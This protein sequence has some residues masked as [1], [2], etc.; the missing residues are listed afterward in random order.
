MRTGDV[1]GSPS[2]MPP[3]QAA[4]R[5]D[6]VGPHSDVYSLGAILY[7]LLTGPTAVPGRYDLGNDLPGA[8]DTS[9]P[10]ATTESGRTPRPGNHLP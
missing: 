3:E 5:A 6:A 9:G 4:S 2:Y 7:E 1:I 10:A 8:L